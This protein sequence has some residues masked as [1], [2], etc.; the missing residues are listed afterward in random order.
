MS[1]KKVVVV[2]GG[3]AGLMAAAR[4][5]NSGH[6]VTVVDPRDTFSDRVR[7]HRAAVGDGP[8][9]RAWADM[10]PAGVAR[11]QGLA[12]DWQ[13]GAV[14]VETA[15]ERRWLR[16]DA[17]VLAT[18]SR[19]KDWAG[20][21]SLD[22]GAVQALQ[23]STG[24]V[25]VVG[26]GATGTELATVLAEAGRQVTLVTGGAHPDWSEAG[27]R[28]RD[29]WLRHLGG[30]VVDAHALG[31]GAGAVNT[32][33]G[34]IVAEVVVPCIGFSTSPVG[35]EWGL[36]LAPDGRVAAASDLSVPGHPGLFVAGD[37]GAPLE[38]PWVTPGCATAMPMGAHAAVS[39]D[40]WLSGRPTAPFSF[41]WFA[42]QVDIGRRRGL[43]QALTPTGTPTWAHAGFGP[44]LVRA[45]LLAVVPRMARWEGSAGRQLMVWNPG[46]APMNA[47]LTQEVA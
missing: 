34:D 19:G 29:D 15:S 1:R 40:A 8:S 28:L 21:P 9:E 43:M 41:G 17:V 3:Y 36:P 24:P 5:V 16:A 27:R 38:L 25:A 14:Q 47:Q 7:L 33:T 11:L 35:R 46:P 18:G 10:L 26:G 44:G 22:G 39:V 32:D 12:R 13:Q 6:D 23:R 2:G 37:V 4:L 30:E 31:F 45:L 20:W 42:R